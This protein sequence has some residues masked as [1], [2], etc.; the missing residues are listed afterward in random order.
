VRTHDTSST[1]A[2]SE[3]WMCGSAFVTVT[4]STCMTVT[5]ITAPVIVHFRVAASGSSAAGGGVYTP[6]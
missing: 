2:D 5:S 4:S 3:P 1:P 6:R